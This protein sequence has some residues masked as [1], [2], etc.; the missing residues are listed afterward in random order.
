MATSMPVTA[1][2]KKALRNAE[3]RETGENGK[4][5]KNENLEINLVQV[6]Y[7]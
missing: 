7:I 5:S 3:T 2:R 6:S 4:N 1:V